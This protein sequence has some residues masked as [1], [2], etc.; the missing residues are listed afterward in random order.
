MSIFN[1][2]LNESVLN[3]ETDKLILEKYKI[4]NSGNTLIPKEGTFAIPKEHKKILFNRG[5]L[6]TSKIPEGTFKEERSIFRSMYGGVSEKDFK[7]IYP[8]FK[9]VIGE[10]G[11][12]LLVYNNKNYYSINREV[13]RKIAYVIKQSFDKEAYEFK[14]I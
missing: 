11:L 12:K 9:K 5:R 7:K 2:H 13:K 10:M 14:N 8:V 1:D 3:K 4:S 6:K